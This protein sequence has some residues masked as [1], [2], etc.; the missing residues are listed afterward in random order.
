MVNEAGEIL[1]LFK[2][3][4]DET[5]TLRFDSL[6]QRIDS[7][8]LAE[9][10]YVPSYIVMRS[11]KRPDVRLE[12]DMDFLR[13]LILVENGY[14]TSLLSSRYEQMVTQFVQALC[15]AK[16]SKDYYD[17]EII[18]ANRHEGTCKS[19]RINHSRYYIGKEVDY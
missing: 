19:I 13:S 7:A 18:I 11:S 16:L 14:P 6:I 9:M 8:W 12:I 1:E 2:P 10:E 5:Y 4:L 17:G 15:A 3:Q